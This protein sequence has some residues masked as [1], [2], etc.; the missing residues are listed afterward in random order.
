[1][2]RFR[3][4]EQKPAANTNSPA[5]AQQPAAE[6][7]KPAPADDDRKIGRQRPRDP[8]KPAGLSPVEKPEHD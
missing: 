6:Q 5:I 2:I 4:I 3:T 1:M 8:E 7:A